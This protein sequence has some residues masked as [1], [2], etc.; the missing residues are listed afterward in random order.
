M[1][2]ILNESL[3]NGTSKSYTYEGFRNRTRLKVGEN[4]KET[5][6]TTATFNEGNQLVK[7]GNESLTYDV[8]S[9]IKRK[10][11]ESVLH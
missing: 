9:N 11:M 4:G 6:F 5:K 8:N 1:N 3:P 7:F 2:S 10:I